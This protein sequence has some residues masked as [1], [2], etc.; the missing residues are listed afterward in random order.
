ML[1]FTFYTQNDYNLRSIK[2]CLFS[3]YFSLFYIVNGLFFTDS[4]MHKIYEDQGSFNFIFQFPLILYSSLICSA[5]NSLVKFLSLSERNI[6]YLKQ[7]RENIEERIKLVLKTLRIK[8][9]FFFLFI[10]IFLIMFWYYISCFCAIYK[11]TQMH[12]I[13]DTLISFSLSLLYPISFVFYQ[14]YLEFLH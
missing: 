3:F 14:E 7:N 10:F 8:F 9:F 2:I 6:L 1:I 5:I 12:L 13:K 4:T 11:N